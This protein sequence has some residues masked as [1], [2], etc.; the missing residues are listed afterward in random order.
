M[1]SS[2]TDWSSFKIIFLSASCFF[3]LISLYKIDFKKLLSAFFHLGLCEYLIYC[4]ALFWTYLFFKSLKTWGQ[5]LYSKRQFCFNGSS[6]I[7]PV[8]FSGGCLVSVSICA[9]LY[10]KCSLS[11]WV[12]YTFSNLVY[13]VGARTRLWSNGPLDI[14]LSKESAGGSA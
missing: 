12:T 13:D 3:C 8:I 4:P 11:S 1:V 10:C 5:C 6:S 14:R 9:A 2:L 7:F